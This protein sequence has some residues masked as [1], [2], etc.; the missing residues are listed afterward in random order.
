MRD[1][2]AIVVAAALAL[3]AVG[4]AP[5]AEA[6][7]LNAVDT[8]MYD[9]FIGHFPPDLSYWAGA[10]NPLSSMDFCE[11]PIVFHNFFMFDLGGLGPVS[12][13]TLRIPNDTTTTTGTYTVFD[14]STPV[15]ELTARTGPTD[16]NFEQIFDDLASGTPFGSIVLSP[17]SSGTITS[18]VFN[19]AGIA[20]IN[21]SLG[22]QF[23]VGGD[24]PTSGAETLRLAFFFRPG[25][26][27]LEVESAV[28]EPASVLMLGVGVIGLTLRKRRA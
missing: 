14:V 19:A 9:N 13:A 12:S 26:V 21:N 23:A 6:L 3:A 10:C 2:R 7:V 18:I 28:P 15:S 1:I 4:R 25:G 22:G 27:Q 11:R 8:G 24:F 17:D 20:A 16:P 5:V